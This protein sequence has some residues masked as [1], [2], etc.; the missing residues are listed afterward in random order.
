[1]CSKPITKQFPLVGMEWLDEREM[2]RVHSETLFSLLKPVF[3][4]E[5]KRHDTE[6]QHSNIVDVLCLSLWPEKRD[7]L[8]CFSCFWNKLS[9]LCPRVVHFLCETHRGLRSVR[10]ALQ[11][12]D[13]LI[14]RASIR[15]VLWRFCQA[16]DEISPSLSLSRWMSLSV[17][18]FLSVCS[19]LPRRYSLSALSLAGP[20]HHHTP[21]SSCDA[22][23]G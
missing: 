16:T 6:T 23:Y 12:N 11:E 3:S 20:L 19:P 5:D 21:H 14:Y 4:A 8:G 17:S 22:F 10:S 2:A 18:V 7:V 9:S 1:M 15:L 13:P